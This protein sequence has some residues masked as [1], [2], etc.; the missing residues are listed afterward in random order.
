MKMY[1]KPKNSPVGVLRAREDAGPGSKQECRNDRNEAGDNKTHNM[2]DAST[3]TNI[4]KNPKMATSAS[5]I[6]SEDCIRESEEM[7]S[8]IAGCRAG[9]PAKPA[10]IQHKHE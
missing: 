7:D 8:C 6:L 2:Q 1:V 3:H 4:P 5:P 9:L 10:A